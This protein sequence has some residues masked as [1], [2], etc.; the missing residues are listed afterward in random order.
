MLFDIEKIPEE[1]REYVAIDI[2]QHG[3]WATSHFLHM[4]SFKR[5]LKDL[6]IFDSDFVWTAMSLHLI[7]LFGSQDPTPIHFFIAR[8]CLI[9]VGIESNQAVDM[10]TRELVVVC[11]QWRDFV[12]QNFNDHES[13]VLAKHVHIDLIN[14]YG[15]LLPSRD[16]LNDLIC[17]K[18][19]SNALDLVFSMFL[20]TIGVCG[21]NM[22]RCIRE[23]STERYRNYHETEYTHVY[24]HDAW[25]L[26]IP[27]EHDFCGIL[28]LKILVHVVWNEYCKKRWNNVPAL[29]QG[30]LI[31]TIKP[32]LSKK[33]KIE[34]TDETKISCYAENGR[35]VLRVA[36]VDPR[37]MTLICKGVKLLPSLAGHKLLRWQIKTGYEN[38][39]LDKADPRLIATSGG[40]EGIAKLVG[41]G[42]SPTSIKEIKSILYAQAHSHFLLPG[43]NS[44]NMISLMEIEKHRNGE[45]SKINIVLGE[46]L[47]PGFTHH[48][49]QGDK[50]RLVPITDLPPLIGSTNTYAAQA[51]LQLLILEEFSKQSDRLVEKKCVLIPIK[52]WQ[53]LANEANL[54]QTC[55]SKVIEG[56]VMGDGLS[57]AFLQKQGDEYTLGTEY[58]QE[59]NFLEY[60]GR[61][62]VNGAKWGMKS[63]EAKK[64]RIENK[65]KNW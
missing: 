14:D 42:K 64:D 59:L 55:L 25:S 54:P 5:M 38:W 29:P 32:I 53:E 50:K 6:S 27:K 2:Q 52:K 57:K 18:N 46:M 44:G 15:L 31:P 20:E 10:L 11:C 51:M 7:N 39:I 56:W 41:C 28:F 22:A 1:I 24:R 45:P 19:E 58:I 34:V 12:L 36:C 48:L 13:I 23:T 43:G 47:F 4:A 16:A 21:K 8:E 63:V 9:D 33:T 37:L 65:Y 40:Y 30:V 3:A 60:Q 62:R 26:W 61:Q 17:S 49:P 35:L